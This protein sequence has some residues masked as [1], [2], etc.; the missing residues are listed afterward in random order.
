ML[1]PN[2]I[3]D[4]FNAKPSEGVDVPVFGLW[5]TPLTLTNNVFA[6]VGVI[7]VVVP[8]LTKVKSAFG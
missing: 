5:I 2:F 4:P 6:A 1:P 8:D 7:A 3:V